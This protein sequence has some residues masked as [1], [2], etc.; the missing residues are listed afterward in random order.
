MKQTYTYQQKRLCACVGVV[1]TLHHTY[2]NTS[3]H[4]YIYILHYIE[5]REG[6][7]GIVDA[8][9]APHS[10]VYNIAVSS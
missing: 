6:G 2:V 4:I 1:V 9:V 3:I 5:N 8:I 7:R 10:R